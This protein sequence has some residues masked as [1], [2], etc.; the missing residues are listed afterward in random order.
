VYRGVARIFGL[1]G[2][3]YHVGTITYKTSGVAINASTRVE[4]STSCGN[5]RICVDKFSG[6]F[7]KT[8]EK[9][10][11]SLRWGDLPPC[12][13]SSYA[14]GVQYGIPQ[15]LRKPVLQVV[16]K[17]I[18]IDNLKCVTVCS[19]HECKLL[20][21]I[22]AISMTN[23]S[24]VPKHTQHKAILFLFFIHESLMPMTYL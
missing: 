16:H 11:S 15:I 24:A 3:R 4:I 7:M 9:N 6:A 19:T 12:P 22:T 8:P 18:C 10:L 20:F 23:K 14:P 1:G 5:C 17:A 21:K 13:P 2:I